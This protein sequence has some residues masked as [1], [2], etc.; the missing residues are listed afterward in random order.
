MKRFVLFSI[1][2]LLISSSFNEQLVSLGSAL[3][4]AQMSYL[5]GCIDIL[6]NF[7]TCRILAKK[8]REILNQMMSSEI[9]AN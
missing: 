6:K 2:G 3:N 7:S 8:H 4:Q 9:E 5:K 1:F